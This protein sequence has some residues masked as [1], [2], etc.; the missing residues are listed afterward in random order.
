MENAN[1]DFLLDVNMEGTFSRLGKTF[2]TENNKYF[3][4]VGTGKVLQCEE[5]VYKILRLLE[6]GTKP[7]HINYL[8]AE[9][10][11]EEFDN[12][13]KSI[14]EAIEKENILKAEPITH[15]IGNQVNNLENSVECN[16]QLLCMELTQRCNLR[17]EYCIYNEYNTKFRN[18]EPIDLSFEY[19]KMAINYM[20]DHANRNEIH[21]GFYGG[22]PLLKYDLLK[23]CVEYI[24]SKEK[25]RKI[26]Y[27]MTTNATLL[28]MDKAEY[29]ASI[30]NFSIVF[31]IDGSEKIHNKMRKM[32]NGEDSFSLTLKGFQNAKKAYGERAVQDLLINC[33][34]CP[35]YTKEKFDELQVFFSQNAFKHQIMFTYVD[36]GSKKEQANKKIGSPI[37][38]WTKNSE[39]QRE[40]FSWGGM[41]K[42]FLRIH[43]RPLCDVP[44]K[45][46]PFNGCC[47][48]G[49]RR[50]YLTAQ[51][52]YKVCER[53]GEAPEIGDVESGI[54]LNNIKKFYVNE[55]MEKSIGDCKNCWLI[56]MCSICY[57]SCFSKEGLDI[58]QKR[59]KCEAERFITEEMM[60]FY[61]EILEKDPDSLQYLNN[62][63]VK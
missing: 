32:I 44:I 38:N 50:I 31:S 39:N 1:V 9:M 26:F 2:K 62:I 29:F 37:L 22:E 16:M 60:K 21:F 56:D 61:H 52:K 48:P 55:Y 27:S 5:N 41:T 35:P 24:Q 42:S 10:T 51:G 25:S 30:P 57:S 36:D 47:I 58:E 3:Y 28:T 49:S 46:H 14:N 6:K 53:I 12:G 7:E 40:L 59:Q 34:V 54:D 13:I 20:L 18:F 63:T 17:C 23:E 4:D 15:F 43:K 33:V 19:A 45:N 8:L 11:S